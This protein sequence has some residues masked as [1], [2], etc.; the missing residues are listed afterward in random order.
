MEFSSNTTII[1]YYLML[2]MYLR[3]EKKIQDGNNEIYNFYF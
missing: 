3:F 2:H 1:S